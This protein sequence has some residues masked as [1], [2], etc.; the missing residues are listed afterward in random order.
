M[1]YRY[2]PASIVSDLTIWQREDFLPKSIAQRN[3]LVKKKQV[4][5]NCLRSGHFMDRNARTGRDIAT[6]CRRMHHSLLHLVAATV[7]TPVDRTL[8]VDDS[9]WTVSNASPDTVANV[10]NAQAEVASVQ[11]RLA[12]AWVDLYTSEGRRFKVRALLDQGSTLSFI[13]EFLC[14]TLRTKRQHADLQIRCFWDN[15]TGLARSKVTLQ[16]GPF[17]NP[18]LCFRSQRISFNALRSLVN[19]ISSYVT[20]SARSWAGSKSRESAAD[21]FTNRG[22]SVWIAIDGRSSSKFNGHAHGPKDSA[23]LNHMRS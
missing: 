5:F 18:D 6:H 16:L 8:E 7:Q 13:S 3:A 10:Q 12:T 19:S 2:P 21:S 17:A 9:S 23:R 14:Q 22:R 1:A 20:T 11:V 4:C 15:Y